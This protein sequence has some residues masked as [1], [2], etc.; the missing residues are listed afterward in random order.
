[1]QTA[2]GFFDAV[3]LSPMMWARIIGVG[4][5]VVVFN[6]LVKGSIRRLN[7]IRKKFDRKPKEELVET[8]ALNVIK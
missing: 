5:T 6:E 4:S 2:S 7:D 8:P 3:P 1:T